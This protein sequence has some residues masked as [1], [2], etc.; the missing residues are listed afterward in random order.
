VD[1]ILKIWVDRKHWMAFV[2]NALDGN[3]WTESGGGNSTDFGGGKRL[4]RDM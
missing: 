1:I 2:W 3:L 4:D